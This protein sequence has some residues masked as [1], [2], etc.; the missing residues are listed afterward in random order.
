MQRSLA[1]R[2]EALQAE[3]QQLQNDVAHWNRMHPNEKPI[4]IEPITAAEIDALRK[5]R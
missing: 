2:K 4:V 5:S 3:M 1:R